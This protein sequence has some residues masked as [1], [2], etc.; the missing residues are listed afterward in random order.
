MNISEMAIGKEGDVCLVCDLPLEGASVISYSHNGDRL[1]I[2]G[3]DCLK[4]FLGDPE[5]YLEVEEDEE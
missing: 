5:K 1:I 4:E 3:N 2:C